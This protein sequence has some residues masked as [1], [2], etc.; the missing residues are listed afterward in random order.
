M[1]GLIE[2]AAEGM[3]VLAV[4][5][6]VV[7][8]V[9]GSIRFLIGITS[10]SEDAYE[11]YKTRL[12]KGLL[13]GLEFLVAAD[14]VRTVVLE[15]TLQNVTIL[16]LLVVIRTFLSWS[17]VV[18]IEGYWPWRRGDGEGQRVSR[19]EGD[20]CRAKSVSV[21]RFQLPKCL[22]DTRNPTTAVCSIS[23]DSAGKSD[24]T[25]IMSTRVSIERLIHGRTKWSDEVVY[26]S[27]TLIAGNS[28]S[29]PRPDQGADGYQHQTRL[30]A[31]VPFSGYYPSSRL[32][33]SCKRHGE[34]VEGGEECR[35]DE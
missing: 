4:A 29:N 9:H 20:P 6:I 26:R 15:P 10:K 25:P 35:F 5:V 31:Y 14:V 21:F 33:F 2:I 28:C 1:R 23:I 13:L 32:S 8:I 22:P 24:S 11:Q 18:E 16:G 7:A 30:R 12:G 19:L 34:S 17:L 3:E 27:T